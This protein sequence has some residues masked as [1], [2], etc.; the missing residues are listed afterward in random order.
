MKKLENKVAVVTGA[1]KGIGAAIAK[2]FAAAGAKVVVNYA[3]SKESAD[4]V[5]K[6]IT[7]N[8][9]TAISVQADVSNE[10]DVNRLFEN[11]Q[12]TFGTLDILVNN[13]VAQGYAPIEQISV[14]AFHKSFNV[15]VLGPV[16]TIQ[17]ALK[18]FS[19]K[20]GNIINISSGASKYPLANAS[21]YSSTKAALD[22]FTIALSKELGVKN[23]R[24]N[25]ILPG[26]TDTEGAAAAG[27]TAGS[28]YEKMF[29]EKTPLGRRGQPADIA[30]VAVFLASDEAAWITGEQ[31][32]VSGGMYGF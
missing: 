27:V 5:V 8:G 17:A 6:E 11:T 21:L 28:E 12:K 9:G 3:T 14:E 22:A 23:V 15:N 16:L 30:K 29:V 19:N 1:S 10:T 20:G 24:I 7:D 13:S 4:K 31:I 2:H 25:S 32:S 26:A 18:L